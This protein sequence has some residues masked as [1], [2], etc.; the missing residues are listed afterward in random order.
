M[1]LGKFPQL[2]AEVFLL[3]RPYRLPQS[4]FI[5]EGRNFA[6]SSAPLIPSSARFGYS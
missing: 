5:K 3:N 2:R 6:S 1:L 4:L